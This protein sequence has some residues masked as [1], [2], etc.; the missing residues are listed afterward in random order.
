MLRQVVATFAAKHFSAWTYSSCFSLASCKARSLACAIAIL[1]ACAQLPCAVSDAWADETQPPTKEQQ[2]EDR[3]PP[4][5]VQQV[6]ALL[7]QGWETNLLFRGLEVRHADPVKVQRIYPGA[8]GLAEGEEDDSIRSETLSIKLHFQPRQTPQQRAELAAELERKMDALKEQMAPFRDP[9]RSKPTALGY[10]P[11]TD[12]ERA[13]YEQYAQLHRARRVL[14]DYYNDLVSCDIVDSLGWYGYIADPAVAQEFKQL[15]VRIAGLFQE[16]EKKQA[17]QQQNDN[18]PGPNDGANRRHVLPYEIKS[19][20]EWGMLIDQP[21]KVLGRL[22]DSQVLH[23]TQPSRDGFSLSLYIPAD[24][25]ARAQQLADRQVVIV[26]E[27]HKQGFTLPAEPERHL[28]G[29]RGIELSI[30]PFPPR[31]MYMYTIEVEQIFPQ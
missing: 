1:T 4:K 15:K 14:P 19:R 20:A 28:L 9:P 13:L 6:Q 23:A 11:R 27:L 21:V 16:Y 25:Q 18:Q 2:A 7:P 22:R 3:V 5:V 10:M 8:P 12:E 31:Q 30:G 17:E 26:G 24:M 29:P